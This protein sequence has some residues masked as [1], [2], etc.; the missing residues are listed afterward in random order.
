M[1]SRDL[2]I[3]SLK[4]YALAI[5]A[6]AL[7]LSYALPVIKGL[8]ALSAYR[9]FISIIAD[10]TDEAMTAEHIDHAIAN[11]DRALRDERDNPRWWAEHGN[12]LHRAFVASQDPAAIAQR[13]PWLQ[14]AEASLKQAVLRNP[15][16]AWNFYELGRLESRR[17]NSCASSGEATMPECSTARYFSAA[18][19]RASHRIFLRAA[20]AVWLAQYAPERATQLIREIDL[21]DPLHFR[22]I[23]EHLWT[24]GAQN[25]ALIQQFLPNTAEMQMGV[26]AYLYEQQYDYDSDLASDAQ[27]SSCERSDLFRSHALSS[28]FGTDDGFSEWRTYLVSP[29]MRVKKRICLPETLQTYRT[30]AIKIL[31]HN[32]GSGN[33]SADVFVD[34]H[35]IHQYTPETPVPRLMDWYELPFDIG[36]LQGKS[37]INVYVRVRGASHNDNFLQIRGDH[38]TNAGRSQLNQGLEADLSPDNGIQAGEYMIRLVLRP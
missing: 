5:C 22:A 18:L 35:L 23:V 33:F 28:E 8:T 19:Q 29:A 20:I 25:L 14:N 12:F 2:H 21:Q 7:L 34:N 9:R 1:T 16:D 31:M 17:G 32:G 11:L 6:I 37:H 3:S 36:L 10:K 24:M 4:F 15:A 38:D 30:A 13:E 27:D 26:A